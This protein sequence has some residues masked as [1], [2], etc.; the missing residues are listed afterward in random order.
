L[1]VNKRL[2]TFRSPHAVALVKQVVLSQAQKFSFIKWA[3][4]KA[5]T[6]LTSLERARRV[7]GI[8]RTNASQLNN[9]VEAMKR[10]PLVDKLDRVFEDVVAQ[11]APCKLIPPA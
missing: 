8:S 7:V 5:D 9:G 6:D 3:M 2:F 11:P 4:G 10:A 1:N